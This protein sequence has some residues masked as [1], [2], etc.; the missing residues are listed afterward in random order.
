M[1][2]KKNKSS[3][4]YHLKEK[5][6][7]E[8]EKPEHEIGESEIF[9]GTIF[10]GSRGHRVEKERENR[11]ELTA[12]YC[13]SGLQMKATEVWSINPSRWS[14]I[15]ERAT[16]LKTV[17]PR[18]GDGEVLEESSVVHSSTLSEYFIE[19]SK[20]YSY[21]KVHKFAPTECHGSH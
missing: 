8:T 18:L 2:H 20:V 14:T 7:N 1:H 6:Q 11:E 4:T 13:A 17:G 19:F 5:P 21:V 16:N 3:K 9:H 10:Q 15:M 12:K